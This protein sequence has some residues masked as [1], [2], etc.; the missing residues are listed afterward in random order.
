MENLFPSRIVAPS[1][2]P[3]MPMM[4][5]V[6][7]P[8][9]TRSISQAIPG[10]RRSFNITIM[11]EASP[12][13]I[14]R[15]PLRSLPLAAASLTKVLQAYE[16]P[17]ITAAEDFVF[18]PTPQQNHHQMEDCASEET[19]LRA[20]PRVAAIVPMLTNAEIDSLIAENSKLKIEL[21]EAREVSHQDYGIFFPPAL[22]CIVC[23][24]FLF[25]ALS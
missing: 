6:V 21:Q 20:T 1:K 5:K 17:P 22:C 18:P 12:Q 3:A 9:P 11:D 24:S 2:T 4:N 19:F 8:S 23:A 25:F 15:S 14:D 10:V 7:L 16:T 13:F